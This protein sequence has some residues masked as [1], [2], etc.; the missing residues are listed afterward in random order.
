MMALY[1]LYMADACI[2]EYI[3]AYSYVYVYMYGIYDTTMALY[4]LHMTDIYIYICIY[5]YIYVYVYSY[6]YTYIY[7]WHPWHNYGPLRTTYGWYMYIHVIYDTT[8]ALCTLHIVNMYICVFLYIYL[9][10]YICIH[11]T[12]DTP[13]ALCALHIPDMAYLTQLWLSTH[14]ADKVHTKLYLA[15]YLLCVSSQL[16]KIKIK[17]KTQ[18]CNPRILRTSTISFQKRLL[19][20]KAYSDRFLVRLWVLSL[21]QAEA[22]WLCVAHKNMNKFKVKAYAWSPSWQFSVGRAFVCGVQS[23]WGS[24]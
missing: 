12:Y 21:V 4:T 18:R 6:I 11:G 7:V 22:T 14:M 1:A 3:F 15:P 20:R 5:M 19:P 9:Y 8:M 24:S 2:Y 10:M 13:M 17:R 16:K 23:R